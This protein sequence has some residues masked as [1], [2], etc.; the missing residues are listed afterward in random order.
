MPITKSYHG[1]QL[2]NFLTEDFPP[3]PHEVE[4]FFRCLGFKVPADYADF[5]STV[6]GGHVYSVAKFLVKK[7]SL[8]ITEIYAFVPGSLVG[9]PFVW[10]YNNAVRPARLFEFASV[11]DGGYLALW[12]DD[13]L[14][15]AIDE[16][17]TAGEVWY[18]NGRLDELNA[19]S[20]YRDLK[21][22][23]KANLLAESFSSFIGALDQEAQ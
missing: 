13:H 7:K 22:N 16:G 3:V 8:S 14:D 19:A 10:I 6:N 5:L 4:V 11:S 15:S 18:L 9:Q 23:R 21:K 12:L 17:A 1:L 20:D 2:G